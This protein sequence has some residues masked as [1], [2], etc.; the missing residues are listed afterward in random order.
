LK[1]IKKYPKDKDIM[2]QQKEMGNGQGLR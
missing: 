1:S 2:A